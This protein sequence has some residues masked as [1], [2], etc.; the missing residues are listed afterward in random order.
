MGV[1]WTHPILDTVL[2]SAILFGASQTHTLDALCDRLAVTIPPD[3]RHTALGDAH[4]TA[5]VFSR[6]LPMLE[7]R[8]MATLS[9]VL[10]ETKRHGRLIEDMN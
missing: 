9:D 1:E 3:L 10:A 7:A 5:E 8:G 4:A 6:M 2:L